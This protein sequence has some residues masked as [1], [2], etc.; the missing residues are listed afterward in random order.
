MLEKAGFKLQQTSGDRVKIGDHLSL[1]IP[2]R[3]MIF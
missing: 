2:Y 3:L 1:L